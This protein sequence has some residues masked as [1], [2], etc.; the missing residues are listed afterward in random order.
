MIWSVISGDSGSQERLV[1]PV[2]PPL[3]LLLG[4]PFEPRSSPEGSR[5]GGARLTLGL[6]CPI[7]MGSPDVRQA[8][9]GPVPCGGTFG[10]F[11]PE[12]AWPR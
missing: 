7:C 3:P 1:R 11:Y 12:G 10:Q 6:P 8:L 9:P 5:I 4:V 2:K